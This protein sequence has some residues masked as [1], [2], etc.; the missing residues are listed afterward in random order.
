[1]S[2]TASPGWRARRAARTWSACARASALARVPLMAPQRAHRGVQEL[3]D[4]RAREMLEG[5]A[6]A[7]VEGTER[8]QVAR[9][10]PLTDVLRALAQGDDRRHDV[11]AREPS[12]EGVDGG[13]DDRLGLRCL[14]G[15]RAPVVGDHRLEVVDV[16]EVDAVEAVDS[17]LE[18]AGDGQVDQ[19]HRPPPAL[20]HRLAHRRRREE[21]ALARGGTDDEVGER[22]RAPEALEGDGQAAELPGEVDGTL[23]GPVDDEER[24][25]PLGEE[26]AGR[27][28]ADRAGPDEQRR[29]VA[30]P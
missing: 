5:L 14:G 27:E 7:G 1:M 3:V 20:A 15:A 23:E 28:L 6:L 13:V 29:L 22:Q 2:S 26:L 11:E 25:H 18:G 10:L 19:E 17:R 21:G 30:Q 8:A 12:P 4:D 9:D 24:P 16:V